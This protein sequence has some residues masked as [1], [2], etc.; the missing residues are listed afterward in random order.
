MITQFLHQ[1]IDPVLDFIYPPVCPVCGEMMETYVP[2]CHGCQLLMKNQIN[3]RHHQSGDFNHLDGPF[4]LNDVITFWQYSPKIETCIHLVKYQSRKKLG[5]F[6]V[7][8]L[9]ESIQSLHLPYPDTIMPVPLHPR[10]FRERGYNQSQIYA[11]AISRITGIE[12]NNRLLKRI[13]Y[14]QT[15]TRLSAEARQANVRDAFTIKR[16][17]H[18]QNRAVWLIDDVITSG[19]T[20]NSCAKACRD[21]GASSVIGIGLSRPQLYDPAISP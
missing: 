21:A 2:V 20:I 11:G 3:I 15:Q 7:R 10:R 13:R 4:F 9:N 14:T 17:S 18:M 5:D 16:F 8:M 1:L 12:L 19:A 6:I